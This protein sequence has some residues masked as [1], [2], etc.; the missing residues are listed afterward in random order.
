MQVV[1]KN[2]QYAMVVTKTDKIVPLFNIP[3]NSPEAIK[4]EEKIYQKLHTLGTFRAIE[5]LGIDI[6]IYFFT[7][8]VNGMN[9]G[10]DNS[11]GIFPWRYD[12]VAKFEF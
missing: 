2:K 5:N 10:D 1:G 9:M 8:S 4:V 7:V 6:P 3:E 12:E 11:G